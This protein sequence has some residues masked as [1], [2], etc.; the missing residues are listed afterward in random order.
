MQMNETKKKK[1]EKVL[2][3]K[4]ASN[5]GSKWV[6]SGWPG[7]LHVEVQPISKPLLK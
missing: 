4:R 2:G 6:G 7:C 5:R 3:G 1:T